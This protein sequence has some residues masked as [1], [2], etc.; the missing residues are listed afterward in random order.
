[1]NLRCSCMSLVLSVL[2][3]PSFGFSAES[4]P[5]VIRVNFPRSGQQCINDDEKIRSELI[6]QLIAANIPDDA[7]VTVTA[8]SDVQEMK[9]KAWRPLPPDCIG[10]SL[11]SLDIVSHSRLGAIRALSV[12]KVARGAGLSVFDKPPI[13]VVGEAP[14][15]PNRDPSV[16]K[17]T[18]NRTLGH[19][20]NY[21]SVEITWIPAPSVASALD[22][23]TYKGGIHIIN[24]IPSPPTSAPISVV[25]SV[26]RQKSNQHLRRLIGWP[27]A[28]IGLAGIG[29][30]IG[31]LVG[32]QDMHTNYE[33]APSRDEAFRYLDQQAA[34][35]QGGI[36]AVALG[37][38][39][40]VTGGGL[41]LS[42]VN[43]RKESHRK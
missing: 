4:A 42:T 20:R 40:L 15:R 11:P 9:E 16:L 18:P 34:F 30:G 35:Q 31:L 29:A 37:T 33:L 25:D 27:L 22:S 32:A 8:F 23:S 21:R 14:S 39:L 28:A 10:S 5:A 2:A 3:T 24:M 41:L 26:E 13:I 6:E 7:A 36:W 19:G 1:M 43:F 12:I 38:G 17:I